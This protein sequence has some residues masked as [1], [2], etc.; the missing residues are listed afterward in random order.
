VPAGHL[1][2]AKGEAAPTHHVIQRSGVRITAWAV[3][4][5][6][7]VPELL[8][9]ANAVASAIAADAGTNE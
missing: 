2:Y 9:Q 4:L 5:S 1:I 7:P 3:D 6:S 8:E